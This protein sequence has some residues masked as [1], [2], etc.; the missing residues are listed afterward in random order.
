MATFW[1]DIAKIIPNIETSYALLAFFALMSIVIALRFFGKDSP[2]RRERIFLYIIFF[3]IAITIALAAGF[4]TGEA[5]TEPVVQKEIVEIPSEPDPSS[6]NLPNHIHQSIEQYLAK[7]NESVTPNSKIQVLDNAVKAYV[8]SSQ[9]TSTNNPT[10]PQQKA[11]D[12][13]IQTFE[14]Q[15]SESKK[16][17]DFELNKC[18]RTNEN[19]IIIC[20]FSVTN[21][22]DDTTIDIVAGNS[23]NSRIVGSN[24]IA[25]DASNI[26]I[27]TESNPN[28]ARVKLVK[29]VLIRGKLTFTDIPND[30]NNLSL[31][32][33]HSFLPRPRGEGFFPI[34][35][36]DISL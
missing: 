16:G 6:I 13:Q 28:V 7:R 1:T 22:E 21:K 25:Y 35:F 4:R 19:G 30:I 32:E 15:A 5:T 10:L 11:K 9:E 3:F 12:D 14:V 36:R 17:L 8:S 33:I 2:I 20:I 24:G 27:G 31:L 23:P 18:S 29:D 26:E 34:Q